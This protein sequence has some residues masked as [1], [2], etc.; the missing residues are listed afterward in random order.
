MYS[1][2]DAQ[3]GLLSPVALKV[4]EQ[5]KLD[6]TVLPTNLTA[7]SQWGKLLSSASY[8]VTANWSATELKGFDPLQALFE[9]NPK[10]SDRMDRSTFPNDPIK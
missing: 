2:K 1:G 5:Y 7:D 6:G 9:R 8:Q 3:G 10:I 4:L